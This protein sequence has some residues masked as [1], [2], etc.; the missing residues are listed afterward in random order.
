VTAKQ[1]IRRNIGLIIVIALIVLTLFFVAY[2]ENL[3]FSFNPPYLRLLLNAIFISATNIFVA[4]VS[5]RSFLR[6]GQISFAFLSGA[7][8]ASGLSAFISG[9][10]SG[11]PTD[12][13]FTVFNIGFLLSSIMQAFGAVYLSAA[14]PASKIYS[15]RKIVITSILLLPIVTLSVLTVLSAQGL[16]A[17]FIDQTGT[18]TDLRQFVIGLSLL[19]FVFASSIFAY[20]YFRTKARA[21]YWYSLALALFALDTILAFNSAQLGDALQWIGRIADY[22]GGVFFI[23]ALLSLRQQAFV[24]ADYSERLFETF[25]NNRI[26]LASLFASM[27]SGFVYLRVIPRGERGAEDAIVLEVNDAFE[28]NTGLRRQDVVGQRL[29]RVIPGIEAEII[30]GAG[31]VLN[32]EQ[33]E[34]VNRRVLAFLASTAA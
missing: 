21:L 8:V 31:H 19:F 3:T 1:K 34:V 29:S 22:I 13:E 17:P 27:L 23:I 15:N 10:L 24:G 7:L 11:V 9:G 16:T 20:Q 6:H 25:S 14:S 5:V 33:A 30:Q 26:Q 32:M 18:T 28:K 12:A 2:G 4:I